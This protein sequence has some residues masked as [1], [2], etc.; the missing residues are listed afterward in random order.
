MILALIQIPLGLLYGNMLE[1]II[2]KYILHGLGKNNKSIWNFHWHDHH[3]N[4]RRNNFIDNDYQESIFK[5][6]APT[7]E[8]LSLL[9]LFLAHIPLFFIFPV[10]SF[11]LLYC[12]LNYYYVHQRGHRDP[13]WANRNVPWHIDHHMGKNQD[14]N[15]CV[16]KPWFDIIMNTR[17]KYT[18]YEN[19][20]K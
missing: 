2:H 5:F 7:K 13:V 12:L 10:F 14:A 18:D 20:T 4:T 1:W 16:T 17:I 11:T 15:W 3:K 8:I 9:P 6:H 19:C